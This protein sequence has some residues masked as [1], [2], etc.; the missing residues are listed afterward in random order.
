[1]CVHVHALLQQKQNCH[2]DVHLQGRI[3]GMGP[4]SSCCVCVNVGSV[5]SIWAWHRGP[6]LRLWDSTVWWE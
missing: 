2:L 4:V 5:A 3:G 6:V 1:M